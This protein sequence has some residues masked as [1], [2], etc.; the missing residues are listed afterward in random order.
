LLVFQAEQ[1]KVLG[2]LTEADI[3]H[4]IPR[5]FKSKCRQILREVLLF[6][7]ELYLNESFPPS[8]E[9]LAFSSLFFL[10]LQRNWVKSSDNTNLPNLS[11][12]NKKSQFS[13]QTGFR[14]A[15]NCS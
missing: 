15:F 11:L 3:H 6:Q 12:S 2:L 13:T 4:E 9:Y 5:Q 14:L 1:M 10:S 8:K 7:I